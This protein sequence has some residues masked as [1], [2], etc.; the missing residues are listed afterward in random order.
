MQKM[1]KCSQT[2]TETM[3]NIGI[4]AK[5]TDFFVELSHA[6]IN[7]DSF[8]CFDAITSRNIFFKKLQC[9]CHQRRKGLSYV[10]L[11]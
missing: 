6:I 7:V 3:T 11:I 1:P 9:N 8:A 10:N 5:I 4:I 2:L